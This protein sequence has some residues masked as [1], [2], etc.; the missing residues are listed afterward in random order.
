MN[1]TYGRVAYEAWAD[2]T[3]WKSLAS[4]QHIPQWDTLPSQQMTQWEA[5]ANAIVIQYIK[6]QRESSEAAW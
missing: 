1:K 6:N 4:G 5:M 3:K 2:H